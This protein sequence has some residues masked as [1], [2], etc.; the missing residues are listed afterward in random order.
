M[1][2]P[3]CRRSHSGTKSG[4]G[5]TSSVCEPCKVMKLERDADA[6]AFASERKKKTKKSTKK[7]AKK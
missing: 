5:T 4:V 7:A 6:D 1:I 2:C 3:R